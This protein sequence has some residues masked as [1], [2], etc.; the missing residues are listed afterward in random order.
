MAV[1]E[2]TAL[3]TAEQLAKLDP[4]RIPSH[5]AIIPD[6]NRRWA[7]GRGLPAHEG[8]RKGGDVLIEIVNAAQD[9]G[10]STITMYCFST[11]NWNRQM[12]EVSAFMALFNQYLKNQRAE[13]I[14][15]GV[16]VETIG[17]LSR[18]PGYLKSTIQEIKNATALGKG[19]R[20]VLALN[21]GGRHEISRAFKAMLSDYDQGLLDKDKVDEATIAGYMDTASFGDPQL[22]I[23]TS[24]EQR[25][26]NFLLWQICYSEIHVTPVLWPDF[27][28]GHLLEAVLDYQRRDKRI[29]GD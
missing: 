22:L 7:K 17:E 19:I 8:H 24:G 18:L 23:R 10:I 14:E 2:K 29:G 21:Y 6:G 28:P 25:I 4:T 5:I 9:M 12:L 3:F 26:S 11:E 15:N 13:M 27:T 16:R 20:L 1:R